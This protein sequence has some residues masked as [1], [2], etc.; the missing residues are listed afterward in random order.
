MLTEADLHPYQN[1]II[2]A[3]YGAEELLAIVPMGGGKTV[4]ALTAVQEL[5][6][7]GAIRGGIIL[8]PKR[9]AREVW[10]KE[11][12]EWEHLDLDLVL[13]DGTPEQRARKLAKCAD[14]W[15][16]G[17][18]NTVWLTKE[19]EENYGPTDPRFD[20]LVVDEMSRYKATSGKRS[21]A[22]SMIADRFQNRWGL[23]GTPMPNSEADLFQPARILTRRR[24][25]DYDFA[26]WQMKYFIPDNPVTQFNWSLRDVYEEEIWGDMAKFCYV[27]DESELPPQPELKPVHHWVDLP[28]QAMKDYDA[29]LKDLVIEH[30]DEFVLAENR[31]VASGKLDQIAQGFVYDDGEVFKQV[32]TAKIDMLKELVAGLGGQQ[33]MITYW[34][35]EDLAVMLTSEIG[36]QV[37]GGGEFAPDESETIRQWNAGELQL[38]AVH[39]AS[40]GHG[41]NLQKSHAGQIIHYCLPWSPELLD[42][43]RK[44]IARQGN[45]QS[46]VFEHMILARGTLDELKLARHE[47]KMNLQEAFKSYALARGVRC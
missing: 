20:L 28:K 24:I 19:L 27:V 47:E 38:L 43:V 11:A 36:I 5:L 17:I 15:V 23:T 37:L 18:D 46:H 41:L 33:A 45:K 2:T 6:R 25:W 10:M 40:A 42:Q 44:R 29:M 39:P 14:L 4:C 34:F 8:P 13:V 22:L 7:D 16:V 3:L 31:G 32:H 30:G 35:K 12:A 21:R 26:T 9:V 1:A